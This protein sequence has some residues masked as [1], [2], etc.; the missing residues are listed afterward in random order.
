MNRKKPKQVQLIPGFRDAWRLLENNRTSSALPFA[1]K[2]KRKK[3]E[4][5]SIAISF[6]H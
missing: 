4:R 1:G 6:V 2:E 3:E 5:Q